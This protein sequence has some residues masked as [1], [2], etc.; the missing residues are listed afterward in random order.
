MDARFLNDITPYKFSDPLDG[1]FNTSPITRRRS[2]DSSVKKTKALIPQLL[3]NLNAI[4]IVNRN[5]HLNLSELSSYDETWN[6]IF[7]ISQVPSVNGKNTQKFDDSCF[8]YIK[9]KLKTDRS[10]CTLSRSM[11][12]LYRWEKCHQDVDENFTSKLL[13]PSSDIEAFVSKQ[14]Q[15]FITQTKGKLL[16]LPLLERLSFIKQYL[17][18]FIKIRE[19]Q[20][21]FTKCLH[22][23]IL[24]LED[25][26]SFDSFKE[27]KS[28]LSLFLEALG[29]IKKDQNNKMIWEV[30][31]LVLGDD[32]KSQLEMEEY[33]E[34]WNSLNDILLRG[35]KDNI[36]RF[37]DDNIKVAKIPYFEHEWIEA[38]GSKY[39]LNSIPSCEVIRCFIPNNQILFDKIQIN[40]EVFHKYCDNLDQEKS[41]G[42]FFS[43]LLCKLAIKECGPKSKRM[44]NKLIDLF[45][46]NPNEYDKLYKNQSDGIPFLSVLKLCTMDC[47]AHAHKEILE[48]YPVIFEEPYFTRMEP[49]PECYIDIGKDSS[50]SVS[51]LKKY[52]VYRRTPNQK[53]SQSILQNSPLFDKANP[54]AEI[55]FLWTVSPYQGTWKGRLKIPDGVKILK[56]TSQR[57]KWQII[58]GV[59][60]FTP[61]GKTFFIEEKKFFV[62]GK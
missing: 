61:G 55:A 38:S 44:D 24:R 59:T 19:L 5:M 18:E 53:S 6:E 40:D 4:H 37:V 57:E 10:I 42:E 32:S 25:I 33:F 14:T 11:M 2:D 48:R 20:S 58:N 29:I 12:E 39:P 1:S 45:V 28:N 15:N 3:L 41:Q 50:Y 7:D 51:V 27:S 17:M 34:Y 52:R 16:L 60:D 47:W 36:R 54:L 21:S 56:G 62:R 9:D 22:S 13:E 35:I 23:T 46:S 26:C 8:K 31:Q 49:G 30:I 43:L